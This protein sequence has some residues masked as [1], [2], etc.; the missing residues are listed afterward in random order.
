MSSDNKSMIDK[1]INAV[2]LTPSAKILLLVGVTLLATASLGKVGSLIDLGKTEDRV[3]TGL[4]GITLLGTGVFLE[5]TSAKKEQ[6]KDD[7]NREIVRG[8]IEEIA[9]FGYLFI[10]VENREEILVNTKSL[11]EGCDFPVFQIS[12]LQHTD[13]EGAVHKAINESI[14]NMGI[15]QNK[16]LSA[17]ISKPTYHKLYVSEEKSKEAISLPYVFFKLK[18]NQKIE[19]SGLLWESFGWRVKVPEIS[20]E[21]EDS[22]VCS[23]HK[24]PN[25]SVGIFKALTSNLYYES[26]DLKILECVDNFILRKSID[27]NVEFLLIKRSV[28]NERIGWEY[29]KGGMYY[30]ETPL[31]GALREIY[32]ETGLRHTQLRYCADLGWQTINVVERGKYYD[33]LHV[34]GLVFFYTGNSGDVVLDRNHSD[35]QWVAFDVARNL[36]KDSEWLSSYALEFFDRLKLR[37]KEFFEP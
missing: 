25:T 35:F 4:I 16:L 11:I 24:L 3:V 26:L 12:N 7:I 21:W 6:E 29:P 28:S 27:G 33:T 34:H 22:E 30:H 10:E 18:L 8:D 32:E 17:G 19:G 31:E 20:R 23:L 15:S 37:E 1:I 14:K 5:Q 13:I 2:Q 36:V 9:V